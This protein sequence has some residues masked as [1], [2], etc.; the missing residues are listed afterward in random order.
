LA[1]EKILK[2]KLGVV[3]EN[4]SQWIFLIDE[5]NNQILEEC[6]GKKINKYSY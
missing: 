1:S 5:I 4:G 3:D 6:K 2:I